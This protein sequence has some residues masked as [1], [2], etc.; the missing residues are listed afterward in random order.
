MIRISKISIYLRF[1]LLKGDYRKRKKKLSILK[2]LGSQGRTSNPALNS[3][4]YCFRFQQERACNAQALRMLDVDD[5]SLGAIHRGFMRVRGLILLKPSGRLFR[6]S[7]SLKVR[8]PV[9]CGRGGGTNAIFLPH[10]ARGTLP[11]KLHQPYDFWEGIRVFEP[12][13]GVGSLATE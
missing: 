5:L 10:C 2:D 1:F 11:S 7:I 6:I 3:K 9:F 8:A 4:R 13:T 12:L